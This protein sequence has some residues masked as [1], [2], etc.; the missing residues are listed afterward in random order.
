MSAADTFV[1]LTK[2][3]DSNNK[4]DGVT[5]ALTNDLVITLKSTATAISAKYTY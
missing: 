2:G 5:G 1:E 3:A 4:I